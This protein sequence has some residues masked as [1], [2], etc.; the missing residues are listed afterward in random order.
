MLIGFDIICVKY[1]FENFLMLRENRF[2]KVD[3]LFSVQ[4][5]LTQWYNINKTILFFSE[6][7]K[8]N[9]SIY[10]YMVSIYI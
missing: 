5:F 6:N 7:L 4:I 9:I 3:F 2:C 10:A 8:V 1:I